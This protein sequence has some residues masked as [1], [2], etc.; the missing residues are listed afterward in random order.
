MGPDRST[1]SRSGQHQFP[2]LRSG[3]KMGRLA[4]LQGEGPGAVEFVEVQIEMPVRVQ[5]ALEIRFGGPLDFVPLVPGGRFLPPQLFP[6]QTVA[7]GRHDHHRGRIE[8]ISVQRFLGGVAEEGGQRI[9]VLLG[10]GIE[11]VVVA[12]G[13]THRQAQPDRAGGVDPVLGVHDLHFLFDDPPFV[14]GDVAAMEAG[15]DELLR[16]RVGQQVAG[17]LVHRE[18]VEGQVPVEGPDDPV[19]VGP[20]LAVVVDMQA[21]GVAV[22]GRIEPVA[23]PVLPVGRGPHEPVDPPGV[24][25]RGGIRRE[26]RHPLRIGRQTGEIQCGP[27][28]QSA[29]VRLRRRRQTGLLEPGQD[30]PVDGIANPLRGLDPR[31]I[32]PGQGREGPVFRPRGALLDPTPQHLDLILGQFLVG[33]LGRHPQGGVRVGDPLVDEA[34]LR[35]AWS[36][37]RSRGPL[38]EDPLLQVQPQVRQPGFGIRSVALET[39]VGKDGAHLRLKVHRRFVRRRTAAAARRAQHRH[40]GEHCH[41]NRRNLSENQTCRQDRNHFTRFPCLSHDVASR[42]LP[43]FFR[44]HENKGSRDFL[45]IPPIPLVESSYSPVFNQ[46]RRSELILSHLFSRRVGTYAGPKLK[47]FLVR[48]TIRRPN[49]GG[50]TWGRGLRVSC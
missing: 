46:L 12:G 38:G 49:Q 24:G 22:A 21:V 39:G 3:A 27:A 44:G 43:N 45:K 29:A 8:G 48:W 33:V 4:Q 32:G 37:R 50:R 9:E 34:R 15:G 20:H 1:S 7:S 16:G 2:L 5:P 14:G 19:A 13:A 30:E 47:L 11:L 42:T 26:L 40:T 25:V 31:R 17:Q 35:V 41:Q 6:P 10:D 28:S 18:L 36:D 23:A